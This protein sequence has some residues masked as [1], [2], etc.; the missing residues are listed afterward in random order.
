MIKSNDKSNGRKYFWILSKITLC[1]SFFCYKQALRSMNLSL[2]YKYFHE[3]NAFLTFC[4]HSYGEFGCTAGP[5][6]WWLQNVR[7]FMLKYVNLQNMP[8]FLMMVWKIWHFAVILFLA[9]KVDHETEF[10]S[11]TTTPQKH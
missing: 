3:K 9:L 5:K 7:F 11:L 10:H 2:G 6:K 4:M 8:D 1:R